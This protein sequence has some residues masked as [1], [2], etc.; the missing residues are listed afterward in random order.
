[1]TPHEIHYRW[2]W[3]LRS[4]PEQLWPYVSDTQRFNRAAVGYRVQPGAASDEDIQH[5]RAHYVIPLAWDEHPFEWDRPHH[6][7]VQRRFHGPIL[8]DFSA[9][10]TLT[11]NPQGTLL[12]YE[13]T[14]RPA[15]LLGTVAI[16]LQIG[17][18]SRT[19]FGRAFR[20]IDDFL[21]HP[22][23]Q[24]NP[25][26]VGKP[27]ITGESAQ[28]LRDIGRELE[29]D[30]YPAALIDLLRQFITQADDDEVAHLRPYALADRWHAPRRTVLELCLAATRRSLL[31]LRW[32]I[33][34]PMCRGANLSVPQLNDIH[35]QAY[36]PSCRMDFHVNFDHAV[37]VTFRPNAARR[38][39]EV[40][41]YCVGG[42]QLTPHII[43]QQLLVSH[44][45]RTLQLALEP[46]AHRLRARANVPQAVSGHFDLRISSDAADQPS[47]ALT[48]RIDHQGWAADHELAASHIA[49]TLINDTAYEQGVVLER[50]AWNDQAVTAADVSTLQAFRDWFASQA[51]R[52]DVQ[53]GITN[54]AVLFTDLRGSTQLYREI[55]DAPAFERVLEHFEVLRRS[56]DQHAGAQIKTIGDAI[57]AA[58]LDPAQGVAAGLEILRGMAQL[59]QTRTD[60][61]LRLKLGL[62]TGA[63]IAVT[64]NERLD[65]FGTTVNIASRLE[66]QAQGDDLIISE[67]VMRL[68]AVQRVLGENEVQ[69]EM[70]KAQL[71]G[72]VN[73]EFQLYRIRLRK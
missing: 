5:L 3:Q 2:E 21:Q 35:E 64:L 53:L 33:V 39:I 26:A 32:D 10:T 65:Y 44:E 23:E 31:D 19:R 71:K 45:T 27:F 70:F 61:P 38:P 42:P 1:M 43:A 29:A 62:H 56:V 9:R 15:S 16:P 68:P 46:G 12:L 6:F 41:T 22:I 63:A 36:C 8:R 13:V 54:L 52:P 20:R 67:D 7:S 49:L 11:P 51:L 72:F 40:G 48:L 58:F 4:T 18:L 25:L 73:E 28:R 30:G 14:A 24:L 57:M 17:L 66:G 55:G 50:V 69:V 47:S 37:E 59:N 60:Y 34:C